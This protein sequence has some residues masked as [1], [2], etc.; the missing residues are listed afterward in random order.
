M[1]TGE[2]S[3]SADVSSEIYPNGDSFCAVCVLSSDC[4]MIYHGLNFDTS[5]HHYCLKHFLVDL[6]AFLSLV[7][8]LRKMH[9]CLS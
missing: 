2:A 4:F 7:F 1:H 8:S 9:V 6:L 5:F 3:C